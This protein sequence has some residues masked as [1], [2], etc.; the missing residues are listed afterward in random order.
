GQKLDV[1]SWEDELSF[2]M[3]TLQ[4]LN[5]LSLVLMIIL[6]GIVVTGI[7]NTMWIAIRERTREIG[8]LRAIGLPPTRV[9]MLF[10]LESFLLGV[11]ATLCG[12]VFGQ[13]IAASLNSAH[14]HVPISVQLFL[15]SDTVKLAV[16]PKALLGAVV[17]ISVVTGVAA[18]YP[19]F[20]AS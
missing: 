5:G 18:A 16:L 9:V 14:M 6:I 1:T 2:M 20:R 19:A 10:L 8:T 3:W 15:M 7:M 13:V 11:L 4:A 17:L 12:A